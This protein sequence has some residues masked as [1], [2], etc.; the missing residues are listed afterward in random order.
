MDAGETRDA[1]EPAKD[2]GHDSGKP[3]EDEEDSG[4]RDAGGTTPS[5]DTFAMRVVASGLSSPWEITWGP[6][7]WLWITERTDGR[8]LRMNPASAEQKVALT[9]SDMYQS[10][11]QD[12][13]LGMA[14]NLQNGAVYLAYTYDADAGIDVDRRMRLV[15]YSYDAAAGTLGSPTTLLEGLPASSDHNSGRLVYGPDNKLYYTIGDQGHNQFDNKCLSV[16][17]QDIPTQSEVD[18]HDWSAYQGKILRIDP[19]GSVP[20][21]NP[22]IGGVRSHVYSYGHRNAQGIVFGSDGKLYASEQGPKTDDEIN[23]IS[24]GKNYGWPRVAGFRDDQGYVYGNWSASSPVACE[25]LGYSDYELPDSVP[26]QAES[27]WSHPDYVPPLKTFYTV[28]NDYNFIDPACPDN[29]FICWPTIAPSSIDFYEPGE[30]G[31]KTWG[32]ALLLP[33]LKLGSVLRVSLSANGEATQGETKELWKTVNRY[34]DL[35]IAPDRRTF[36]VVTDNDGATSGP[37]Q[38]STQTLTHRGAV[39]E[40][41]PAPQP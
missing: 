40:F 15:R 29:P 27:T 17:A 3:R 31:F 13:L 34:R 2:A 12:G 11:G 16:R 20:S 9:L 36:Y 22:S 35:T 24:A 30:S 37:T 23:L 1:S 39:L 14:L 33:S 41:K 19:D 4:P 38:G 8:V 6:D 25:S 32:K 5:E 28:G 18:A 7:N 26:Q 21:D 10:S